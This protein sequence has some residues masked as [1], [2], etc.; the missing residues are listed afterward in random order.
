MAGLIQL[1]GYSGGNALNFSGLNAGIDTMHQQQQ[2]QVQ[3][4]LAQSQLG[5]QK[6][7]LGMERETHQANQQQVMAQRVGGMA[8]MGLAEKDP[9]R[10]QAI[11]D[12]ALSMHPDKTKLGPE[13]LSPDTAFPLLV[14]EAQGFLGQ[15]DK[16]DIEYKQAQA[17]KARREAATGGERPMTVKEWEFYSRLPD[18]EKQKYITMKRADKYLNAGDQFVQPNPI[19]PGG[20]PAAS[21]PIN[22]AATAAQKKI[23]EYQGGEVQRTE[24]KTRLDGIITGIAHDYLTLDKSGGIVNPDKGTGDNLIARARSSGIGQTIAGATGSQE[25]SV[26]QRVNNSRPL[27]IQGIM[28]AT[29]MSARAMDSNKELDFYLQAVSNPQS[30]LHSNLVALDAL[31]RTYGLG[32]VLKKTLP[33]ELYAKVARDSAAALARRPIPPPTPQSPNSGPVTG[34]VVPRQFGDRLPQP[35]APAPA[36]QPPQRLRY[37][38]ATGEL[39]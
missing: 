36:A 22:V 35:G 14:Q 39:E 7:R 9:A 27:L 21:I 10:R 18:A 6:E 19:A 37:N 15:K 26:R 4:H 28:Q 32:G 11:L 3:N 8:Q 13:Y 33:P 17:E 16:A 31:D 34:P 23:G 38:P 30:D 12:R 24:G 5:M 20:A 1:P 2:Q 25:Q 29:G